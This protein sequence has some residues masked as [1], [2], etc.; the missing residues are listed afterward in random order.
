MGNKTTKIFLIV[1]LSILALFLTFVFVA[2]LT[3][4]INIK[5]YSHLNFNLR[6]SKELA[7]DKE[8]DVIFNEIE[9]NTK[10]SDIEIVKG[11]N[12]KTIEVKIYGK[13]DLLSVSNTDSLLRIN[14]D[15]ESCV[16]FCFNKDISKIVLYLPENY[17]NK[18]IINNSFGDVDIAD[19]K[20]A[21]MMVKLDSGDIKI[22]SANSIVIENNSGDINVTNIVEDLELE[23]NNGDVRVNE[24][25]SM[26]ATIK[27]GDIN[28]KK[29]TG[30]LSIN[31]DSGDIDID[32]LSIEEDSYILSKLGDIKINSTN[33]IFI[34]AKSN[35]GEIRVNSNYRNANVTLTIESKSGDVIVK[36]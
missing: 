36:N 21:N 6:T 16:G 28:V 24:V 4:R 9:V 25:K 3:N 5:N 27:H 8:F 14:V 2:L 20:K 15:A 30:S 10:S 7:Y 33:E 19:F 1:V 18:L 26:K 31:N 32:K 17:S 22:S 23:N 11:K 12:D 35:L 34:N 13:K 29:V